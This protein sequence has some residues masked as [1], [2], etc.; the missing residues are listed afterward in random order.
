MGYTFFGMAECYVGARSDGTV[1]HNEDVVGRALVPVR[2]QVVIATK[3][4]VK[5][6]SA[7]DAQISLA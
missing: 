6:H 5:T 2:N 3:L 1:A 4:G 7:T